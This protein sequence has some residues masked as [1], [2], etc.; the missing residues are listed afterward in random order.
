VRLAL[1]AAAMLVSSTAASQ[2]L[3]PCT[4]AGAEICKLMSQPQFGAAYSK[5]YDER[6]TPDDAVYEI[7]YNL[8][9]AA[10]GVGAAGPAAIGRQVDA[11]LDHALG[12]MKQRICG[13]NQGKAA[14]EVVT[15]VA[16][17]LASAGQRMGVSLPAQ[18][19]GEMTGSLVSSIKR[20]GPICLC[21]AA[22][23]SAIRK[24]CSP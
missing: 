19:V 23:F 24:A 18:T 8:R 9:S 13:G 17:G 6:L 10:A 5:A 12:Q 2:K 21:G 7:S 14:A 16:E 11:A 4:P 22:D 3:P 20:R 1:A 15:A